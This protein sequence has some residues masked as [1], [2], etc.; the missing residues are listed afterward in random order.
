MIDL[1]YH[2]Y[3]LAAVIVALAIGFVFGTSS[4]GKGGDVKQ[5]ERIVNHYERSISSL[6]NSLSE[7]QAGLKTVRADLN[8]ANSLCAELMPVVLKGRL[9]YRNVAIVQTGDYDDLVSVVRSAIKDAGGNVTSVTRISSDFDF[10]DANA[11]ASVISD[12]GVPVQVG[13]SGREAILR[14]VAEA[15]VGGRNRDRLFALRDAGV[16]D[17]SGDYGRWNRL[18]VIVGGLRKSSAGRAD[19]VDAKLAEKLTALGVRVVC[20]EPSDAE[21]SEIQEWQRLDVSTVDSADKPWGRVALILALAGQDGHFGQKRTAD[22]LIPRI[23]D[24]RL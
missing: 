6:R 16:V 5:V 23:A 12:V 1:R 8:R 22:R 2:V 3:S 10:N 7:Q 4:L 19:I 13:E 17:L 11:V 20:C 24:T 15:V 14:L 21:V 9:A 18:V